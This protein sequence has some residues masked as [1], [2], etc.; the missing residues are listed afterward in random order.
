[1]FRMSLL[2]VS[3]SA[4]AFFAPGASAQCNPV[5]GTGCPGAA[6]LVCTGPPQINQFAQVAYVAP[7]PLDLVLAGINLDGTLFPL[8]LGLGCAP[9]C[10]VAGLPTATNFGIGAAQFVF[11]VPNNPTLVGLNIFG[12]AFYSS[13]AAGYPCWIA[14][15]ALL[16]TV[17]P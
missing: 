10:V 15:N 3:L 11:F 8:P 9:G 1:M 2:A 14:S 12:Q 13:A 5:P 7:G 6:P 4:V 17:V 16:G